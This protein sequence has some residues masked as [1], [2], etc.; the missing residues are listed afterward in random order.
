MSVLA[1]L[2][3]L[4]VLGAVIVDVVPTAIA[5]GL[6]GGWLTRRV[7]SRLWDGVRKVGGD[8]HAFIQLGGTTL[9]IGLL[10]TWIVLL[11]L[12]WWLLFLGLGRIEGASS[13]QPASAF[14]TLYFTGYVV[15]TLGNGEFVPGT[16][17]GQALTAIASASGI[18]VLTLSITYLVPVLDAVSTK[19]RLAT[20]LHAIGETPKEMA[21]RLWPGPD[22]AANRDVLLSIA[23]EVRELTQKHYSYPVLHYF[24]SRHCQ[25]AL[26]PSLARL[27]ET[28]TAVRIVHPDADGD[29]GVHLLRSALDDL[30]EALASTFLRP[31]DEVPPPPSVDVVSQLVD[32]EP[33]E[34]GESP[35]LDEMDTHRRR[36]RGF[37]EDDGW[38]W[39]DVLEAGRRET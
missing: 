20:T 3:G 34:L 5:S 4:L 32:H 19:R 17:I 2:G 26:P 30:L 15:S 28:V 23:S 29:L 31:A 11:V 14:Q 33:A 7:G 36:L 21:A 37:V 9:V 1:I 35:A 13:G 12:G 22:L 6:P 8:N 10:V 38:S 27:D 39:D 25:T 24:H 18:L 16:G